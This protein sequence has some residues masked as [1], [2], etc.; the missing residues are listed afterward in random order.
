V[1][2]PQPKAKPKPRPRPRPKPPAHLPRFTVHYTLRALPSR[3]QVV[4][5]TFTGLARGATLQLRC[6]RRCNLS[7]QLRAD[8]NG[9]AT[10][11]ALLGR[12]LPR[13]SV[14][15]VT[16]RRGRARAAATIR[17]TGLPKGFRIAHT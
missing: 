5:L 7:E 6:T 1:P 9:T 8:P 10:S 14:L 13:G 11:A 2:A 15:A 3:V 17:V 12:W 4:G 16:E